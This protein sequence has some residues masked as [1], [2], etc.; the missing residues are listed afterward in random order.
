MR[1]PELRRPACSLPTTMNTLSFRNSFVCGNPVPGRTTKRFSSFLG[2]LIACVAGL[3]AASRV[4]AH[5][6]GNF[7]INHYAHFTIGPGELALRYVLDMAEIPTVAERR[8]MNLDTSG[9][10]TETEKNAYLSSEIRE[11]RSK[12]TLSV[13]DGSPQWMLGD[14]KLEFKPG[15]GGLDT[16]RLTFT[17]TTRLPRLQSG[18]RLVVYS[19]ANFLERTGWKEIVATADPGVALLHCTAS[20]ADRSGELT[21]YP[22]DPA[23]APPQQTNAEFTMVA[24]AGDP[25]I[26]KRIDSTA[27]RNSLAA[28]STAVKYTR[29]A[30]TPRDAFTQ[31]IS[32]RKLTSSVVLA[33]LAIAFMFGALHA[34][35]P[36]HGKTMV[37]AYLV[38]ARGTIR[39]AVFLGAVITLTHTLGV[40]ALGLFML[41]ATQY[42][43]PDRLYTPISV[44]SGALI[45]CVGAGL[46][47]QHG[48]R[49]MAERRDS[50]EYGDELSWDNEYATAALLPDQASASLRSLIALGITGGALPCPSALVVMLGAIALHRIA[51]GMALIGAFSLGLACV[52]T[53][54]GILVVRISGSLQRKSSHGHLTLRLQALSAALVT[55]VGVCLVMRALNGQP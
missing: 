31:A 9:K 28:G 8:R 39:H 22:V 44:A 17:L 10:I 41:M 34:L 18:G 15:A 33:S 1:F 5:P 25:A 11:L 43:V 26:A 32:S 7:S 21:N 40:F 50:A 23:L 36:G 13:S 24:V 4:I 27:L 3:C 53:G 20:L 49:W 42:V 16:M 30:R 48:T 29:G 38:G 19:D 12:L 55:L 52:L 37:A 14:E 47:W 35:S 54:I 46:L 2:S 45:M 51:F 6:M